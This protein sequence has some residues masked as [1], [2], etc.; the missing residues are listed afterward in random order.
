MSPCLQSYTISKQKEKLG[1]AD[2]YCKE[3]TISGYNAKCDIGGE[4]DIPM[5]LL[6]VNFLFVTL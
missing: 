6:L 1:L 4:R 2:C 5:L 3:V